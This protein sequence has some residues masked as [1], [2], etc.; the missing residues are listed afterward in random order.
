M[1][2][3]QLKAIKFFSSPS[4]NS[5]KFIV[6]GDEYVLSYRTKKHCLKDLDINLLE[7]SYVLLL[8]TK[9][10][11]ATEENEKLQF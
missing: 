9:V 1:P 8:Q 4:L 10:Y 7:K 11:D 3:K 5:N 6:F 2:S